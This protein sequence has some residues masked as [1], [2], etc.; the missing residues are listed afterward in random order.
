MLL[1]F[2]IILLLSACSQSNLKFFSFQEVS[3]EPVIFA[4]TAP[5][6]VS[7]PIIKKKEII[8]SKIKEAFV[9]NNNASDKRL[10]ILLIPDASDSM[11]HHLKQLGTAVSSLLEIIYDYDWQM[12]FTTVDHG[13]RGILRKKNPP[14]LDNW[15]D[16]LNKKDA[17]GALMFLE[18]QTKLLNTKILKKDDLDYQNIF[19]HTL[20]HDKKIDCK[21]PPYCAGFLE[22]PL[23]AL[24]SVFERSLVEDQG[25]FRKDANFVS[26]VITNDDE[27]AEDQG[28]AVR[29]DDVI[30]TFN[31][32]FRGENK[33]FIHY[34]I[35]VKDKECAKS[36]KRRKGTLF[37]PDVRIGTLVAELAKKTGGENI[38]ICSDNYE[39]KL[40]SIAKHIK[41]SIESS[42]TLKNK[43]I[44]DTLEVR[45]SSKELKWEIYG[46]TII[47]YGELDRDQIITVEYEA[48]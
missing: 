8:S 12:A 2:F 5:P 4:S 7:T 30:Q 23:R 27:R 16:N 29:A 25:F 43:P 38:D 19:Y 18:N 42:I 11:N 14:P 46:R 44:E 41:A 36:E 34:N 31:Q 47:F 45:F 39:E 37:Q 20:S 21:R 6:V 26:L 17:F 22:Q 40:A 24:K 1:Q 13:D 3:P 28:R 10:D 35:L 32:V 33:K 15:R 9:L 48:K